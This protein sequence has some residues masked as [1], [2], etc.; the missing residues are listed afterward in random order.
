MAYHE[1]L[2]N[3]EIGTVLEDVYKYQEA[4]V[5]VDVVNP[6]SNKDGSYDN[7]MQK[8][9]ASNIVSGNKNALELRPYKVSNYV[10]LIA[11]SRLFKGDKVIVFLSGQH[12]CRNMHIIGEYH[13]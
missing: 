3:M 13:G 4:R 10:K 12:K 8:P 7:K 11:P 9:V 2:T 5:A 6:T 1:Q